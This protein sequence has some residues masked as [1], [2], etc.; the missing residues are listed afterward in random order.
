MI[1]PRSA[2]LDRVSTPTN[3]GAHATDAYADRITG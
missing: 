3:A 1:F 2:V